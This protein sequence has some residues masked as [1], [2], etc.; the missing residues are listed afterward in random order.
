M[1]K[2]RGEGEGEIRGGR[3]GAKRSIKKRELE[4]GGGKGRR[5]GNGETPTED[6]LTHEGRVG[7]EKLYD[8]EFDPADPATGD[9][10]GDPEQVLVARGRHVGGDHLQGEQHTCNEITGDTQVQG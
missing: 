7:D 6:E 3:G 1:R 8:D 10:D 2:G 5:D 4:N 9:G